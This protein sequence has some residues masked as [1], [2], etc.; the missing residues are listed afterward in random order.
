MKK[1]VDDCA[2]E[3]DLDSIE[4]WSFVVENNNDVELKENLKILFDYLE[5]LV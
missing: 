5:T 4:D 3:C 1:G 2:S